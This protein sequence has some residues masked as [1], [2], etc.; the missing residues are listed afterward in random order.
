[1]GLNGRIVVRPVPLYQP[2]HWE[3]LI[4]IRTKRNSYDHWF[5]NCWSYSKQTSARNAARRWAR[6]LGI[7]LETETTTG[8]DDGRCNR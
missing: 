8:G 2:L 7:T 3:W 4:E 1:M 6:R 5:T